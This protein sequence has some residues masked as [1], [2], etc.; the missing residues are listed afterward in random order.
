[1]TEY[2]F[3]VERLM[4]DYGVDLALFGHV[5]DYSRFL[6]SYNDTVLNEEFAEDLSCAATN[7]PACVVSAADGACDMWAATTRTPRRLCTLPSVALG[8]RR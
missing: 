8:T 1:M 4:Y 5:H 7:T 6:P 3:S 2:P